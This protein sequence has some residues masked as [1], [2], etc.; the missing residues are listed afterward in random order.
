MISMPASP[1]K[2]VETTYLITPEMSRKKLFKKKWETMLLFLLLT[3]LINFPLL[4][5]PNI[6]LFIT[7]M[8]LLSYK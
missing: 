1:A 2:D 7:K 3:L 8:I 6:V 4:H 5:I